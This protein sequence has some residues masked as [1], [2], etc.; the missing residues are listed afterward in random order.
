MGNFDHL[1]RLPD[2]GSPFFRPHRSNYN[3]ERDL[4]HNLLSE[5][6][7]HHGVK[8][9]YFLVSF[10]VQYD[11]IFGEDNNQRVERKF[12]MMAYFDLPTEE[13]RWTPFGIEGLD[14]FSIYTSYN[15]FKQCSGGMPN[16]RVGDLIKPAYNDYYYEITAWYDGQSSGNFLQLDNSLELI[17]RK[18]VFNHQADPNGL[19]DKFD[20]TRGMV[21]DKETVDLLK[22]STDVVPPTFPTTDGKGKPNPFYTP[23]PGELPPKNPFGGF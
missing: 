7:N 21:D 10:D 3:N 15:I 22:D 20:I 19:L 2:R 1:S 6:F 17:V 23:K 4:V 14:S 13:D 5:S 11:R 12:P 18:F 9:E 8:C 16:P